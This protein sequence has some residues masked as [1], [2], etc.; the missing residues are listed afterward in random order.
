MVKIA[1]CANPHCVADF[2]RL[3]DGK[4]FECPPDQVQGDRRLRCAWLCEVCSKT[5]TLEWHGGM[6]LVQPV[7]R[8]T[9]YRVAAAAG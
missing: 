7:R 9:G 8:W 5:H 6:A 3:S 1:Q 4:L 2:L